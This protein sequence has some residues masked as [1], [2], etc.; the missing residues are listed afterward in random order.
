MLLPVVV[1]LLAA[2]L[3]AGAMAVVLGLWLPVLAVLL[4]V[5]GLLAVGVVAVVEPEVVGLLAVGVVVVE[6]VVLLPLGC[7]TSIWFQGRLA[8]LGPVGT[9]TELHCVLPALMSFMP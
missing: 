8:R 5:V 3:V 7:S 1:G 6:A 4:V 9:P 2:V